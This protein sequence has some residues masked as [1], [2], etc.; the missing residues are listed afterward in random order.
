MNIA[1][2]SGEIW[3]TCFGEVAENILGIGKEN[4]WSLYEEDKIEYYKIVKKGMLKNWFFNVRVKKGLLN[5][6]N[7]I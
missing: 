7:M 5:V 1:D 3:V 6:R 4:L 2:I